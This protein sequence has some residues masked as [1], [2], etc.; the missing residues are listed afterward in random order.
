MLRIRQRPG[1]VTIAAIAVAVGMLP[2]PYGYYVLLR[3]FL[4][5]V[6]LYCLTRPSMRDA[7]NW[8]LTVRVTLAAENARPITRPFERCLLPNGGAQTKW[9]FVGES[10]YENCFLDSLTGFSRGTLAWQNPIR[11]GIARLF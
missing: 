4:C 1:V 9:W 7:K 2:L 3:L 10:F 5:G 11:S 6:S 8:V